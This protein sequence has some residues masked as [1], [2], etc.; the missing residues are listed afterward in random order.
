VTGFLDTEIIDSERDG[1]SLSDEEIQWFI[2]GMPTGA[3]PD[4]QA[5]AMLRAIVWRGFSDDERAVWTRAE[6]DTGRV[7]AHYLG[8]IR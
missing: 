4:Y 3:V 6:M 8:G 2:S 1:E 5:E 7:P